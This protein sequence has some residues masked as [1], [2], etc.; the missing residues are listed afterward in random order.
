MLHLFSKLILTGAALILIAACTPGNKKPVV[1]ISQPDPKYIKP[2]LLPEHQQV[3]DLAVEQIKSQSFDAATLSLN[4]LIQVYPSLAGAYV[5][6]GIIEAQ[7]GHLDKARSYYQEALTINPANTEALLQ[8]SNIEMESGQFFDAEKN[9]LKA[10]S[11]DNGNSAVQFNL[12]VLYELY[13]QRYDDAIE[14]YERY[15]ELGVGADIETVKRWIK[16]LERK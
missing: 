15:V 16:L 7:E 14:H 10:Q 13:L 2:V 4:K 11:T 8:L 3:Y 6:L 9:L 12:G 1:D 5:N